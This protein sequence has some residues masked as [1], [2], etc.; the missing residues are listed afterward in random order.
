MS[1]GINSFQFGEFTLDSSERILFRNGR[2]VALTPKAFSL[3]VT[4]LE[5]RGHLVEK[6]H[7]MEAVWAGSFVEQGNLTF[8]INQL[9]KALGDNSQN[10][11]FIETVPRRG[12]RFIAGASTNLEQ[13]GIANRTVPPAAIHGTNRQASRKRRS[14]VFALC[15]ALLITL[16]WY[17]VGSLGKADHLDPIMS[18]PF[19]SEA[20]SRS[21]NVRHAVISPDGKF[22]VYSRESGTKQNLW[23]RNLATA[24]NIQVTP[25]SDDHYLGLAFSRDGSYVYF[26]RKAAADD[27][28]TAIYRVGAFGGIPS[29]IVEKTEGWI[30]LSPDD[31]Q[32]SFVRCL[33]SDADFCS[34][35]AADIDGTNERKIVSRPRPN[36]I[37][38]NQFSPDG[39]SIVFA[40]GQSNNGVGD[41]QL[42]QTDLFAGDERVITS[43]GFFNIKSIVWLPAGD[44]LLFVAME[45]LDRNAKIWQLSP[46]TRSAK[47]LTN[48]TDNYGA[49]SLD[50]KTS[51]MV[52]TQV[53]NSFRLSRTIGG[54]TT[55]L[56]AARAFGFFPNGDIVYQADDSNI[57]SI[58]GQGGSQS[59]LTSD[60]AS[61]IFP[62]V[63]PDGKF[64]YFSSNR[65]GSNHL[66]RMNSDGTDQIQLTQNEG[67]QPSFV[68]PDGKW[69]YY[70]SAFRFNLWRVASEGGEEMLV[71]E[72][73]IVEPALSPNGELVAYFF[74]DKKWQIGILDIR[75]NRQIKVLDYAEGKSRPV[76]LTW[77][78]DGRSI[79]YVSFVNARN[80]LWHQSFDESKPNF[81]ADLGEKE[82]T[83][84]SLSPDGVGFASIGGKW[85]YDAVLIEGLR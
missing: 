50:N 35:F 78:V 79:N 28:Q 33:Y 9:R 34:L 30:S 23:V 76:K 71:N 11:R 26:V 61:D 60:P 66:W 4:L 43:R 64:I 32:I 41:F 47:P 3:L 17:A 42:F 1:L 69:V 27:A 59:Q 29:K 67:G 77:S 53:T 36:R 24:E 6:E 20:F 37:S 14:G 84:F 51:R 16:A 21:G 49:I 45:A 65:S 5:S 73:K 8:T 80:S 75:N 38:A 46:K 31:R 81:L 44:E 18:A 55:E 56:V 58:N 54:Q 82:I 52:A 39:R 72:R 63:S 10:P 83:D 15:L 22:V 7:L 68:S 57:W 13:D 19:K 40:S 2:P 85:V 48:D 62:R 74:K 12:Y 70:V 25:L